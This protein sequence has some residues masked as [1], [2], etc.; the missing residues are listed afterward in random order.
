MATATPAGGPFSLDGT[1]ALVDALEKT[2]NDLQIFT[3]RLDFYPFDTVAERD[4][5]ER[6][7]RE[8]KIP[9]DP[10]RITQPW[11]GVRR[12]IERASKEPHPIDPDDSTEAFRDRQRAIAYTDTSAY[13]HCTQPGLNAYSYGWKEPIRIKGPHAAA[14]IASKACFVLQVQLREIVRYCLFGMGV[15]SLDDLKTR[16][17]NSSAIEEVSNKSAPEF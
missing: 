17:D 1:I 6:Y 16:E 13:V 14:S 7:K 4:D 12:L 10:K 2:V 5:I 3:R 9:D 8:N 11:S 15:V